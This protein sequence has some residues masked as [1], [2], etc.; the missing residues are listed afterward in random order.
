MF[1][2]TYLFLICI[3]CSGIKDTVSVLNTV[4]VIYL[5]ILDKIAPC[6]DLVSGEG[7][8]GLAPKLEY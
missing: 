6:N 5:E 1:S 3:K 7:L 4:G 2:C 8:G